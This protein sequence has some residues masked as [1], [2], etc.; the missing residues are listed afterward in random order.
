MM[1]CDNVR[2]LLWAYCEGSLD[3]E[4][5]NSV[6]EHLG[7]CAGCAR[8]YRTAAATLEGLRSLERIEPADDFLHRVWERIEEGERAGT[9][10]GLAAVWRWLRANRAAV[11]AGALAF[12]IGLFGVRY[13]LERA[14]RPDV[15]V[16]GE[17]GGMPAPEGGYRDDYI[18]REIPD[19]TPVVTGLEAGQQ[20][21]METRFI[22]RDVVPPVPYSNEYMQ[23]VVQPVSNDDSAF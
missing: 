23:P 20:D 7:A 1:K 12:F 18:L 10:A 8:E 15:E 3:R 13:G 9:A 5:E 17:R 22:T 2:E 21:T 14:G 4:T 6:R 11:T 16:A 19:V